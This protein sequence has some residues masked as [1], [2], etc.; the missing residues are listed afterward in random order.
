MSVINQ[1]DIEHIDEKDVPVSRER[2]GG[3]PRRCL[4]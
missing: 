2:V 3:Q 4:V 1:S